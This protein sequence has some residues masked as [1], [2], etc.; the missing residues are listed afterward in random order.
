MFENKVVLV[1]GAGQGIGRAIALCFG[2]EKASLALNDL[3]SQKERLEDLKKEIESKGGKAECFFANVAQFEEVEEM[4]QKIQKTFGR[5]DI[6]VNN[7][8]ICKD[9]TLAKMTVEE[10]KSVIEV[11]LNGVFN[12]SKAALPL[13]IQNKGKIINISSV[14]GERGNFGQTNYSAAKAGI[15]G[16]SKSL[17]KEVGRFGVTVNAVLPGFIETPLTE[18]LPENI[19]SM[20]KNLTPLNRF[21]KP[22][23]VAFLV[24]FLASNKA[25]FITGSQINI[26]GGLMI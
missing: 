14:V 5:L 13:L 25:D 2:S 22:E 12:C 21:G 19:K 1:T 20:A 3:S 10:W 23:E 26:D 8:G 18:N 11:S 4:I 16:F 17:A 9:K 15:L 6:L 24:V 7:A